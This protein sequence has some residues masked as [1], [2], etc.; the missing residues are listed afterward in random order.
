LNKFLEKKC[1]NIY[2]IKLVSVTPSWD[3]LILHL[4]GVVDVNTFFF[5]VPL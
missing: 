1:T 4:F 5:H 3:V 2:S